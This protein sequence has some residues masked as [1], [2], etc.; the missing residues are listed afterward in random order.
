MKTSLRLVL[1]AV[2]LRAALA[3]T[4]VKDF[5]NDPVVQSVAPHLV[6]QINSQGAE[7]MSKQDAR[8]SAFSSRLSSNVPLLLKDIIEIVS[9]A[10][11]HPKQEDWSRLEAAKLKVIQ[12]Q[13]EDALYA[14]ANLTDLDSRHA[15][16][17]VNTIYDTVIHLPARTKATYQIDAVKKVATPAKKGF[18]IWDIFGAGLMGSSSLARSVRSAVVSTSP[19]AK[20]ETDDQVYLHGVDEV[21]YYSSL[22]DG[23]AGGV[24]AK[25]PETSPVKSL[26]L[27]MII[28]SIGKLAVEIHMG[29]S[30]ARL[31]ELDPSQEIVKTIIYSALTADTPLA[32]HA[33]AARELTGM[34]RRGLGPKVPE[35]ALLG[36]QEQAAMALVLKGAGKNEGPTLFANIP[37]VRN[38]FAFS[39]QVLSAHDLGQILRVVFCP[40]LV[41]TSAASNMMADGD[42]DTKDTKD[43]KDAKDAKTNVAESKRDLRDQEEGEDADDYYDEDDEDDGDDDDEDAYYEDDEDEDGEDNDA[44]D[45]AK[46][47]APPKQ[48]L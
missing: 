23:V 10:V 32:D 22:T 12:N 46:A 37:V 5:V 26:G 4:T 15:T 45:M 7:A 39:S 48:E 44:E 24:I 36:I 34:I 6:Q 20:C 27:A 16:L 35:Q 19:L 18:S 13:G 47:G 21:I 25:A 38:I 17:I 43:A 33:L 29:Q 9:L 8:A 30:I 40:M 31:A 3:G 1:F 11:F 42:K 14:S 28:T 2:L 41:Q